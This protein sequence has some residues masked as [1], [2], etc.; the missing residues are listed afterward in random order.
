[1]KEKLLKLLNAKTERKQALVAKAKTCEDVAT[2]R[3]LNEDI[4]VLNEEIRSI[5]E[6]IDAQPEPEPGSPDHRTASVTEPVP[7]IVLAG[8]TA[9]TRTEGAADGDDVFGSLEYRTAFMQYVQ[10]GV[11]IPAEYRTDTFTG[12]ADVAAVIPTTIMD[13]VIQEMK[14]RGHIYAKC[15]HTNVKG[16]VRYPIL[17][18]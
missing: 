9:E 11:E 5:Q 14:V 8:G 17:S 18:L 7:G 12:V 4:E 10:H 16:G 2:L 3:G 13:E 6:M 15:R 1:M